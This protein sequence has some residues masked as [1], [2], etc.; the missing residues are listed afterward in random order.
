MTV[1]TPDPMSGA[2][3]MLDL[4]RSQARYAKLTEQ[5]TSGNRIVNDEDDP[6][7]AF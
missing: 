3:A 7:H 4:A 2:Q 5:V 6:V 1:R